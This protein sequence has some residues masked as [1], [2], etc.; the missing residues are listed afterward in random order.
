MPI[1]PVLPVRDIVV[2]PGVIAPLFVGRPHSL[3]SVEEASVSDKNLLVVAQSDNSSEDP[4]PDDLYSVGT[5]CHVI[6]MVRLPDGATKILIEGHV[7]ARVNE[8][9]DAGDYLAADAVPMNY[10]GNFSVRAEPL[11]RAVLEQFERYVN[12]HPKLPIEIA[13]SLAGVEDPFL[14]ADV[15]ASH[16]QVKLSERQ[17]LLELLN[18]EERMDCLLRLLVR[19]TELLEME[20]SIHDKVRREIERNN[21]EY[22]LREQLK[23]IQ[24]ELGQPDVTP[25]HEEL[26]DKI[27]KA[28]MPKDVEKKAVA[29][30]DRLSK[31]PSMS[32]EATVSRTYIEWLSGMPWRKR[33]QDRLDLGIARSVL[34]EDHYG[35][36]EVKEYIL[37]FLAVQRLKGK[38]T[39]RGKVLCFVGP[40]GVGKTS[41]GKSIARALNR[42]FVNFSLGGMRDEAEI[43]GHRRTYIGSLPGRIIQKINQAGVKNPVMLMDEIDKIGMDFRGDP[44]SALLE[45]LDPEQNRDFTDHFLEVSFDLSQVLFITT[46]NVAHTIPRPLL[47]RMETIS[48]PGYVAEEKLHIAERHLWPKILKENGLTKFN[49]KMSDKVLGRIISE[50]TREA[51]VRGLDRQLSRIARKLA[52]KIVNDHENGKKRTVSVTISA[53]SVKRYLGAP[54]LHEARLPRKD[55][56]GAAMGLAWTESG[57]DVLVIETAVMQGTG[58]VIF[59]GNLGDIMQESAQAALGYLRSCASKYSLGSIKWDKTDIHV[60]VPE[61]AIPKDGP[62]AGVTLALSMLSALSERAINSRIAMTGEITL[63]GTVLPIGGVREK[64][65]AAKRNGIT[66]VIL[67]GENSVDVDELAQWAKDGMTFNFVSNVDEVFNMA[68]GKTGAR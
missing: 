7:R 36:D 33:T 24:A 42:K 53:A 66:S 39:H 65:L 45:V 60:H 56:V 64:V 26:M 10:E 20:H 8:Y 17:E 21:K 12:L 2:F 9:V 38:E 58:K 44:S 49:V 15:I 41:L 23:A 14:F 13:H 6:Q 52:A 11:R 16:I 57:G 61:G 22:Y 54:K 19:E 47:D 63:R 30:L 29:E 5:M 50:Y 31:M 59:T 34:D 1:V 35:L 18:P 67:P 27:K 62:S 43:R 32:A 25:E 4:G 3:K 68:L 48:I 40:P 51:G 28:K 55:S 46:A 37:E